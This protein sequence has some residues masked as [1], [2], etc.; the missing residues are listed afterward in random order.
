MG[1]KV[2]PVSTPNHPR[3]RNATVFRTLGVIASSDGGRRRDPHLHATEV[4]KPRSFL[5]G[6]KG[7]SACRTSATGA[8]GECTGLAR[9]VRAYVKP[10]METVG[11]GTSAHFPIPQPSEDRPDADCQPISCCTA[12]QASTSSW[13]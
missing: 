9:R 2:E 8:L 10:A 5:E 7:S 1:L 12:D 13:S 11:S 4:W 3:D 6:R